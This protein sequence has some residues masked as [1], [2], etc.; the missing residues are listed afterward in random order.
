MDLEMTEH[1]VSSYDEV[2]NFVN[3]GRGMRKR[4]VFILIFCKILNI[5]SYNIL[6]E[7]WMN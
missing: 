6:I 3:E 5:F 1:L 4:I 2:M 7:K